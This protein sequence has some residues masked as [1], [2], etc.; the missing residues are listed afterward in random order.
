MTPDRTPKPCLHPQARHVHGTVLAY[1]LDRCHCR[2]CLEAKLANQRRAYLRRAYGIPALVD[3]GPSREHVR[4]LMAQGV[5]LVR[6]SRLAGVGTNA[7]SRLIY[8]KPAKGEAPSRRVRPATAAAILAVLPDHA[9]RAPV[10]PT[11]T[12]RRLQA[13]LAMGWTRGHL[14]NQLGVHRATVGNLAAGRTQPH[15]RTADAMARTYDSLWQADPAT[16]GIKPW[17]VAKYRREAIERGWVG[18][19]GWDDEDLDRP[20]ARP[21][22]IVEQERHRLDVDDV[23]VLRRARGDLT[24]ALT[25]AERLAVVA[26]LHAAGLNDQEIA[27]RGGIQDRQV[28]R[29][30]HEQGLRPNAPRSRAS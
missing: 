6:I 12:A 9:Q 29:D 25:H 1:V 20:D 21:V 26:H 13:L 17:V 24:L 15:R 16:L 8:G 14:A 10:D 11:G 2:P 19:L 23:V 30:R 4:G 18:P 7:L 5:G 28:A 27:D 22:Q 3:A